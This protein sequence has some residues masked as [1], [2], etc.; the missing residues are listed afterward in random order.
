MTALL[1]IPF[2]LQGLLIA[3]DEWHFHLKRGLPRWERIGHPID[4]LSLVIC[5]LIPLFLPLSKSTFTLYLCVSAVSC[6]L[7][8]KDEFVHKHHCPAAENWVHALLFLNH[9]LLLASAG[10]MWSAFSESPLTFLIDCIPYK[11]FLYAF[12]FGQCCVA[13]I[14]MLYQIIYWNFLWP[15]KQES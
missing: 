8:T 6:L 10:F 13:F 2:I 15:K 12:L 5:L 14:F 4:T 1:T 11:S 7:V 9:P 3:F